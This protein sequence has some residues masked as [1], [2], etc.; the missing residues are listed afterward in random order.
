MIKEESIRQLRELRLP[1]LVD[2]LNEGNRQ[3]LYTDM[4]FDEALEIVIQD[5]YETKTN[6]KINRLI[7]YA[8]FR[9]QT[10]EKQNMLYLEKR[11]FDKKKINELCTLQFMKDGTNLVIEGLTGSGKSFVSNV[12]GLEACKRLYK[13]RYIRVPDL[14]YSADLEVSGIKG[15]ARLLDKFGKYDL[16]IL[17]EWMQDDPYTPLQVHFLLELTERRYL[18]HSTIYCTQFPQSSWS[19]CLGE[20]AHSEAIIDRIIHNKIKIQ[21]GEINMR[22][23]LGKINIK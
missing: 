1:E 6:D 22:E 4:T 15:S 19:T 21:M 13:T 2:I 10:A 14:L 11:D 5:L 20:N 16:L 18:Q 9:Y 8:R 12:I 7:K 23:E 17:D 3:N